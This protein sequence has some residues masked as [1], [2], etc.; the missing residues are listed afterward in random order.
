MSK[1]REIVE[2]GHSLRS[3][4]GIRVRQ[5]LS[6]INFNYDF[7]E[8]KD[9]I[10]NIIL[11]ELNIEEFSDQIKKPITQENKELSVTIETELDERLKELGDLRELTRMIQDARKKSGLKP[12][13]MIDV[14]Y[15]GDGNAIEFIKKYKSEIEKAT[16]VAELRENQGEGF[17]GLEISSGMLYFKLCEKSKT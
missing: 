9:E 3:Q 2:M 14:D 16:N 1:A 17:I 7:G 8:Y 10:S 4:A 6:K 5:P 13:D 12:S 11:P 15:Y